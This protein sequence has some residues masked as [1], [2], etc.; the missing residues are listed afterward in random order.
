MDVVRW[1]IP[2]VEFDKWHTFAIYIKGNTLQLFIDEK[3]ITD[4][5]DTTPI[6]KGSIAI[7]VKG[8]AVFDDIVVEELN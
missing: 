2:L 1:L 5:W 3:K 8:H 4:Y 6:P 7:S